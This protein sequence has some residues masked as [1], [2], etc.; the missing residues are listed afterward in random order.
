MMRGSLCCLLHVYKPADVSRVPAIWVYFHGGGLVVG[1]RNSYAPMLK[2]LASRA[3]C[4]VVNVEY[5]LAPEHKAPAAFDDC[6][7]ATR[8]VLQNKTRIGGDAG[9][10][11]GIGGDS[12]G[13][14]LATSVS[15]DVKGL[16]FQILVYPITDLSLRA[17]SYAEF[18]STPGLNTDLVRWF[19][20]QF[21]V[22]ESQKKN[23]VLSPS[24]P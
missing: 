15:H 7:A 11:V 6:R 3:R 14:H 23:P 24:A 9:S 12:G 8:W 18:E 20:G 22:D 4:M 5:R 17:P 1:S 10:Q 13:G 2:L 19:C 16:A 21:L